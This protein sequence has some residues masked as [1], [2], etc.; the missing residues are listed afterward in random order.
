MA[1]GDEDFFP[2]EFAVNVGRER[3]FP[4]ERISKA[5]KKLNTLLVKLEERLQDREYLA[6]SFSLA[7]VAYAGNFVRLRDVA[8][9]GTVTLTDYPNVAAWRGSRPEGAIRPLCKGS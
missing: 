9:K 1:F 5:L 6:D 8:E 7:D 3:G 2:A 4:E